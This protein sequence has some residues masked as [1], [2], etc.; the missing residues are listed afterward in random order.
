[1]FCYLHHLSH[2]QKYSE[3]GRRD[4]INMKLNMSFLD[5]PVGNRDDAAELAKDLDMKMAMSSFPLPAVQD[6]RCDLSNITP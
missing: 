3:S 2:N 5:R 1:M 6:V 4:W